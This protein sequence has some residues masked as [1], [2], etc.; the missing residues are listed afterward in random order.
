MYEIDDL[1][2]P[3]SRFCP[4]KCLNCNIYKEDPHIKDETPLDI[5]ENILKSKALEKTF[6]FSL[7]GGESQLSPKFIPILE[8]IAKYKPNASIHSNTSG[9]HLKRTL[10]I[11]H[12]GIDLFKEG[13]FRIDISV[14]GI[15]EDYEKVR[16]TKNGWNKAMETTDE[17]LKLGLK[18]TFVMI[19]FKQNYKSIKPFIEMCRNKGVNW[20]IGFA[21]E[22]ENFNN[23]GNIEYYTNEEI[24]E[25]ENTLYD[26]G[27]MDTKHYSNWLWAKSIYTN[28]VPKFNCF[29]G[30]KSIMIDAFGNVYPCGGAQEKRLNKLLS[31]GNIKDYNGDLDSLLYSKKALKVLDNISNK[32]CQPCKLLC[33]HKIEF[34]WGKHTG[35]VND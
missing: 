13:N 16:F 34:P 18:P 5:F 25:I 31:M 26:I 14:D 9:W 8:L 22:S 30:E 12:K 4:G 28:T 17:L 24:T 7:T 35:M 23:V 19:V 29:M 1:V 21:V 33:A 11:A 20:F 10:E 2:Y 27:F 15:K 6:Y 32:N 3:I